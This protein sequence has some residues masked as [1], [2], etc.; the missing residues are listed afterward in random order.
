MNKLDMYKRLSKE[1]RVNLITYCIYDTIYDVMRNENVTLDDDI[2]ETIKEKA[3][4]LYIEDDYYKLSQ[5]EIAHFITECYIHDN[6][7]F[8]KIEDISYE[9]IL[10]AIND[11]EYDF[12][13]DYEMEV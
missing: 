2:V 4:D 11:S 13:E 7:F 12:Y 3:Y 9:D 10:E 6:K 5:S 8:E 1:D